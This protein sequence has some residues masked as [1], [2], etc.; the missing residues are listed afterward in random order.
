MTLQ[1]TN[2]RA[3]Q[4]YIDGQWTDAS[5]R[6]VTQDINPANIREQ[7]GTFPSATREDAKR[8]VDAAHRALTSWARTPMPKRGEILNKAA[9]WIEARVDEIGEALTREEGKTFAE[10]KGEVARGVSI[11][12]YFAGEC[13]QPTGDVYP[14]ASASTFLFAERVPLGV[15]GLITPWN[16][17]V[18]IPTWKMAPALAYGNTVVLK[19]AEITPLTAWYLVTAFEQAGLPPGV[20]NLIVGRGSQA[21]QELVENIKVK[22]ISFTGSNSVGTAIAA[23][24]AGRGGKSQLELGG[25]NPIVIL[26]DA[27]ISRAVELTVQGAML[28]TGQKCT[29]TSRAIVVRDVADA[30]RDTL[31]ARVKQLRVGDG[32]QRD[33]YMGPLV[34]ADAEKTVME[35]IEIGKQEG[36]RLV[37]G[38]EKLRGDEY[39]HGYFVAPTVFD[40]VTP[41]MRI[42]QEEIFGPVVGVIEAKD[43]DDAIA[44]ANHTRFGLSASVVTRDLNLALRFMREIEAGL[45]HV[46]SMTAGAEPQVPFGGFKESSS[47]TREQGKAA[48][49]FFTQWKTVYVDPL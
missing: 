17:P 6:A 41:D 7:L 19:P 25:K 14:S 46:N 2:A 36:A 1:D 13:L 15:V 28:S 11:L 24:V 10:G 9:N 40:N 48:R 31:A 8:A 27:D 21:G 32:M 5:N 35:Y 33:V 47:G 43:I 30:Y 42:A 34:S 22:A 12:R 39:D 26:N 4:N 44:L 16:F 38:G 49:E 37:A 29:A 18:A 3:F 45:V 23:H 20:L